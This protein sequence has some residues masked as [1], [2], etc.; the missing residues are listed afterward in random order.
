MNN[1]TNM[2]VFISMFAV[3]EATLILWM[4]GDAGAA[5]TLGKE[6]I[7]LFLLAGLLYVFAWFADTMVPIGWRV[8][9]DYRR[10]TDNGEVGE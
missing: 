3:L 7:D 5:V 2:V 4:N 9:Q 1:N 8:V 6:A 10:K